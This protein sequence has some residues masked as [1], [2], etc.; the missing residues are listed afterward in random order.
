V[1]SSDDDDRPADPRRRKLFAG[2][3]I[4][5]GGIIAVGMAVPFVGFI[6]TPLHRRP[7]RVWRDIGRPDDFP[8]GKTVKVRYQPATGLPWVGFVAENAAWLRRDS[9]TSFVALSAYCTHTGCPIRW[10]EGANLFLCPCHGGAFHRNGDVA[11]GPPPRPLPRLD[12]R[13]RDARVEM[14]S[15]PIVTTAR[16]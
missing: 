13:V 10:H 4:A 3:S 9:R 1:S 5:A 7:E 12:V 6:L 8:I 15:L 14:L 16:A 11:A 2:L